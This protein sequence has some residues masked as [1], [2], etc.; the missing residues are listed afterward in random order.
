MHFQQKKNFLWTIRGAFFV[1]LF[2]LVSCTGIPTQEEAPGPQET[3]TQEDP[4]SE[5]QLAPG[6]GEET[7][8]VPGQEPGQA[9]TEEDL[10]AMDEWCPSWSPDGSRIIF[11]RSS[12]PVGSTQG[13]R[14]KEI[15]IADL[16]TEKQ[17]RLA[18]LNSEPK[19]LYRSSDL[20]WSSDGTFLVYQDEGGPKGNAIYR[21]EMEKLTRTE[22]ATQTD[23]LSSPSLSSDNS[24]LLIAKSDGVYL[25]DLETGE[26]QR[27]IEGKG[28]HDMVW[29]KE[30]KE[31]FFTQANGT[32]FEAEGEDL[33]IMDLESQEVKKLASYQLHIQSLTY[34]KEIDR[35]FYVIVDRG[36]GDQITALLDPRKTEITQLSPGIVEGHS[37]SQDGKLLI[38]AEYPQGAAP[39]ENRGGIDLFLIDLSDV[40]KVTRTNLTNSKGTGEIRPSFSPDGKRIAFQ[41]LAEQGKELWVM[42]ADGTEQTRLL[43]QEEFPNFFWC[44]PSWSPDSQ[45]LASGANQGGNDDLLILDTQGKVVKNISQEFSIV[46]E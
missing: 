29:G 20:V 7:A 30:E 6:R 37:L 5:E 19:Y 26:E 21:I 23:L 36:R 25:L 42:N 27:K 18:S 40:A 32:D 8:E 43:S 15:W 45:L 39:G 22:L 2:L 12:G 44:P 1:L 34:L 10:K 35:L 16:K 46:K 14:K 24:S 41:V 11:I 31:I 38:Q 28:I 13:E 3:S 17:R 9:E 4:P 33:L